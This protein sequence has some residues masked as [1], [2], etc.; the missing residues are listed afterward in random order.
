MDELFGVG[1]HYAVAT[2][3]VEVDVAEEVEVLTGGYF[4]QVN[5]EIEEF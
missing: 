1:V 4:C 5:F 2:P 3:F